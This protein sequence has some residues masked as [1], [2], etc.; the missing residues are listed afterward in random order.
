MPVFG[1]NLVETLRLLFHGVA[2]VL[3]KY[4]TI[5]F[6]IMTIVAV[7]FFNFASNRNGVLR[8]DDLGECVNCTV[9]VGPGRGFLSSRSSAFQPAL[10]N[11][12]G[13]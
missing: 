13:L 9:C 6:G 2:A 1:S 5:A 10:F 11:C 8:H 7:P 3:Q 4:L 12:F